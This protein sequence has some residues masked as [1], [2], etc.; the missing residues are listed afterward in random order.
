MSIVAAR[1]L[2]QKSQPTRR[3]S[4][5][6]ADPATAP[7]LAHADANAST[8]PVRTHFP[9]AASASLTP[10]FVNP[11]SSASEARSAH[12]RRVLK[13]RQR[14]N[15]DPCP[16]AHVDQRDRRSSPRFDANDVTAENAEVIPLA[17][18]PPMTP[19]TRRGPQTQRECFWGATSSPT[20]AGSWSP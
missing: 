11:P 12:L 1:F 5:Q 4:V 16:V 14:F 19:P 18:S 9:A 8:R 3:R 15:P 20:S 17:I 7:Q 10:I 13:F 2:D 6:T